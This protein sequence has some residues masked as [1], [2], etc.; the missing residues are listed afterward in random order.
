MNGQHVVTLAGIAG[1]TVVLLVTA[2]K[3]MPALVK[4]GT[5]LIATGAAAVVVAEKYKV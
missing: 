3:Q 1:G 4:V 2:F 5:G